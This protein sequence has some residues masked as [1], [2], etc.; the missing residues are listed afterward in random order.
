MSRLFYLFAFYYYGM[1]QPETF[2]YSRQVFQQELF[3]L[4][5][6]LRCLK[7]K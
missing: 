5:F 7:Q 2:F 1:G 4:L 3:S 6:Y